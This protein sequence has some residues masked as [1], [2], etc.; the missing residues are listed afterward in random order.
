MSPLPPLH[1]RFTHFATL[2]AP[3]PVPGYSLRPY[4]PGD[5]GDWA[6][7]L[8]MGGF[9]AWDR[10]R[11]S[12]LLEGDE[13]SLVSEG[14]HFVLQGRILVGAACAFLHPGKLGD[15]SEL[16]LVVVHPAHRGQGLGLRV[17]AAVL[18][19]SSE[20]GH[21]YAFLHTEDQRLAAIKTFLRLGFE[22]ENTDPSHPARWTA[23]RRALGENASHLLPAASPR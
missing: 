16:A 10:Y 4:R 12:R 20:Q 19:Y 9:G 23:V 3:P 11:L 15:V 21:L 22:P 2:V 1:M 17:C 5:E 18:G 7:L 6:D 8:A 14:V 13:A